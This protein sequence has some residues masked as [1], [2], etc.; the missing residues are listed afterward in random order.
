VFYELLTGRVPFA[1]CRSLM[2]IVKAA[3]VEHKW[4]ALVAGAQCPQHLIELIARMWHPI[5]LNRPA[6]R[7][8]H[9]ALKRMYI[10]ELLGQPYSERADAVWH[11][12]VCWGMDTRALAGTAA[13]R[14]RFPR[15]SAVGAAVRWWRLMADRYARGVAKR[16]VTERLCRYDRHRLAIEWLRRAIGRGCG[17][18]MH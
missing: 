3:G 17:R 7:E 12:P 9:A 10:A 1:E 13:E 14:K 15:S 16:A 4:P 5:P 8:V 2:A 11:W 6:A 18:S